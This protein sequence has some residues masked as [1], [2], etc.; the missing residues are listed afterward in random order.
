M[1]GIFEV[2]VLQCFERK[3]KKGNVYFDILLMQTGEK[4]AQVNRAIGLKKVDL[5]KQTLE[6]RVSANERGVSYFIV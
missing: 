4:S 3:S 5:G 2:E 6:I 1:N